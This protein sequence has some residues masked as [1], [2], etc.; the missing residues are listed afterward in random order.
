MIGIKVKAKPATGVVSA[1]F[2]GLHSA[3]GVTVHDQLKKTGEQL[4]RTMR[5]ALDWQRIGTFTGNLRA[6][7]D[8]RSIEGLKRQE[9]RL[10]G[11]PH[12]SLVDRGRKPGM[13]SGKS[14]GK[15]LPFS[16]QMELWAQSIGKPGLG[17]VI[18]RSILRKGVAARPFVWPTKLRVLGGGD[19]DFAEELTRVL[20]TDVQK[21][22]D[23]QVHG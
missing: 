19:R 21:H 20:N 17:F 18:A 5:G 2:L 11:A 13:G 12:V 3:I 16:L 15:A 22:L 7:F 8:V 14:T 4:L 9:L 23:A 1:A 6:K 10:V